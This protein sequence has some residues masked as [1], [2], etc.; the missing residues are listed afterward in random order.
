MFISSREIFLIYINMFS[1][2]CYSICIQS[3]AWLCRDLI[4][5]EFHK[6]TDHFLLSC[7]FPRLAVARVVAVLWWVCFLLYAFK[8]VN[9][10]T[11]N[12]LFKIFFLYY[13]VPWRALNY[14]TKIKFHQLPAIWLEGVALWWYVTNSSRHVASK[15][16]EDT[17]AW[18]SCES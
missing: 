9:I 6:L 10:H 5:I 7:L 13:L 1:V 18:L 2:L 14:L 12:L 4:K 16:G 11:H 8:D 15:M 17:W 3:F